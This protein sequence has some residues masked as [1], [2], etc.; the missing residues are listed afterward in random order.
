MCN[1]LAEDLLD[2]CGRVIECC[3]SIPTKNDK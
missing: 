2:G 3:V 1:K